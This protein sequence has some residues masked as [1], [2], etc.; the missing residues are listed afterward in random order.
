MNTC[1]SCRT[2]EAD[3]A[4]A[5]LQ[6]R[7]LLQ[8]L[9]VTRHR[10]EAAESELNSYKSVHTLSLVAEHECEAPIPLL[11]LVIEA[12]ALLS[13]SQGHQLRFEQLQWAD[14]RDV[15]LEQLKELI[16]EGA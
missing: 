7:Q 5:H 10:A 11:P 13:E 3:L 14:R 4:T 2:L 15:V 1:M 6:Q 9:N 8:E 16:E 12:M